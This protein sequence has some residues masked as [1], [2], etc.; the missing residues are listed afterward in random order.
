[1]ELKKFVELLKGYS[2]EEL[3]EKYEEQYKK[4]YRR[5][6]DFPDILKTSLEDEKFWAESGASKL[7][8]RF[9]N[10]ENY[11]IKMSRLGALCDSGFTT[12]ETERDVEYYNDFK[13]ECNVPI[14]ADVLEY[15][16]ELPWMTVYSQEQCST[17][18]DFYYDNGRY[19]RYAKKENEDNYLSILEENDLGFCADGITG[20][21][22]DVLAYYGEE[23]GIEALSTVELMGGADD[24]HDENVGYSKIDGRPVILDYGM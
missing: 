21:A 9:E 16:D 22:F 24:L 17:Y 15:S 5:E 3:V 4:R 1:M 10:E 8:I 19:S 6:I 2:V 11:V 14:L 13:T 20:W 18:E 12:R 7:C 23:K